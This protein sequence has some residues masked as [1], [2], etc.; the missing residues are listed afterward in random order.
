M[1]SDLLIVLFAVIIWVALIYYFAPGIRKTRNFSPYGPAL[2]VKITKNRGLLDKVSK[3]FPGRAF[4]R[5]SVVIVIASAIIAI[6][7]LGY[8][9]FLGILD[10]KSGVSS[11]A[12]PVTELIG[13]PGIN[14]VIPIGYGAAAL[15][16]AV[17]IH[18][19]FHGIV[20]RKH[21]IK[22]KSVGALFFIIPIGA[23]VEPDEDEMLKADPVVRRRIVAAGPGINI[24]IGVVA[25][26]ILI[27]LMAPSVHPIHN[28][29]YLEESG[30]KYI[31]VPTGSEIIKFGNYS[32]NNVNSLAMNSTL[33]PGKIYNVTYLDKGK[34]K[35]TTMAGGIMII[36]TLPG[37][38]A[39][40][41]L[42]PGGI[43]LSVDNATIRNDTQLNSV[44]DAVKPGD[45]VNI[46]EAIFSTSSATG[47]KVKNATIGTVSK[48]SYYAEYD[49]SA[50]KASYKN[51]S[52]IGV[53]VDYAG[54]GTV[55]I[56]DLSPIITGGII[57]KNPVSN[58][59]GYL[60]LPFEGLSPVPSGVAALFSV[61]FTP[62]VFWGILNTLYWVFWLN[63]LLGITN[64]LPFV[65]LDGG[66]FF[67]D[68]LFIGERRKSLS[69]LKNDKVKIG[70][71]TFLNMLVF[72]LLFGS[73][74]LAVHGV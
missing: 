30:S 45:T 54:L 4:S 73:V 65:V 68:T 14:P 17:V 8:G 19:V 69:F 28:G 59:L 32:G 11:S 34:E 1:I 5:I 39:Y 6:A 42:T 3:R 58:F 46:S 62:L 61:P 7:M 74:I 12:L 27:F 52:F 13:L 10:L 29:A 18:E 71:S 38:P 51:E 26:L 2:M 24:V 23:F 15:I 20:A 67:R 70:I 47:L 57:V 53:T 35:N 33:V 63:F 48:Y 43:I 44:L 9:I 64:A 21:G 72:L 60:G 25:I 36:S 41:N 50:N 49:P 66:Q 55:P 40:D 22:V 16:S 56:S 31:S 37:Y